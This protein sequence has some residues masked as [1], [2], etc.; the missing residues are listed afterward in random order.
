VSNE[1]FVLS[2]KRPFEGFRLVRPLPPL[3]GEFPVNAL[4][5]VLV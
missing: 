4:G 5:G 1:L 2:R 3:A